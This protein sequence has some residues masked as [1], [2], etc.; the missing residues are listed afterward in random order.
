M[1]QNSCNVGVRRGDES[2]RVY[3]K[4]G[5]VC[6]T[7]AVSKTVY[8]QDVYKQKRIYCTDVSTNE[9]KFIFVLSWVNLRETA[10]G[11]KCRFGS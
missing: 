2:G 6:G 10:G 11:A 5:S 3:A 7:E 1:S 8:S 9:I 4:S